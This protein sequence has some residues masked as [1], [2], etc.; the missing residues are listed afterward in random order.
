MHYTLHAEIVSHA[1]ST[2]H[3]LNTQHV[4]ED[5]WMAWG[6]EQDAGTKEI[7]ESVLAFEKP[8][9]VVFNGDQVRRSRRCRV[10]WFPW[11]TAG[12]PSSPDDADF[13]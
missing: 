6:P 13:L 12:H 3:V 7:L 4:G 10:Y 1:S 11:M 2:T 8:D 9:L 5:Y